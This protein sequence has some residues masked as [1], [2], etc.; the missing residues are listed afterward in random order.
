MA[1]GSL[2]YSIISSMSL[3]QVDDLRGDMARGRG[4]DHDHGRDDGSVNAE[5]SPV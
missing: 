3:A 1:L 5:H 2:R 4:H